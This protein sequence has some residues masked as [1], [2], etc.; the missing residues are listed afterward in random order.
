MEH[1]LIGDISGLALDELMAKINE[2]HRKLNMATRSGNARVCDQLRMALESYQVQYQA[3]L[4]AQSASKESPDF[5]HKISI[6]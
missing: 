1:P 5:G 3:K 6:E 4:A 2:L